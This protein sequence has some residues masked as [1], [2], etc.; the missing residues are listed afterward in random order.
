[1]C[2]LLHLVDSSDDLNFITRLGSGA[3]VPTQSAHEAVPAGQPAL[4]GIGPAANSR[5]YMGGLTAFPASATSVATC[6]TPVVSGPFVFP[7]FPPFSSP[8][9]SLREADPRHSKNPMNSLDPTVCTHTF[10]NSRRTK[11]KK[12]SV[13]KLLS[14]VALLLKLPLSTATL[15]VT[16]A[17]LLKAFLLNVM[18]SRTMELKKQSLKKLVFQVVI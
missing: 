11:L 12:L 3:R 18:N 8:A 9:C 15:T 17:L 13:R 6:F 7:F 14:Q 10:M 2:P 16:V 5:P 1:M 4:H